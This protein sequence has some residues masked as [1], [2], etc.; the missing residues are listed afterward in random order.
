MLSQKL[1][2]LKE[3]YANARIWLMVA[4]GILSPIVSLGLLGISAVLRHMN[5]RL[6]W[7][8]IAN[9]VMSFFGIVT[10]LQATITFNVIATNFWAAWLL[11]PALIGLGLVLLPWVYTYK[12]T[13]KQLEQEAEIKRDEQRKKL[14]PEG[15]I[16]LSAKGHWL[17]VGTT[18]SGKT[19]NILRLVERAIQDNQFLA[20]VDGKGTIAQYSLYDVIIKLAKRCGRKVYVLNQ[21]DTKRSAKYNPFINCSAT[22]IKDMLLSM[23][24]WS[25]EYYKNLA[26]SYWLTLAK[27][28]IETKQTIT[29]NC[30][31][32]YSDPEL[33][34]VLADNAFAE[35]KIS[36]SLH[37]EVMNVVSGKEG[38]QAKVASTRFLTVYKGDGQDIFASADEGFSLLT[39]YKENAIC[40]FL[41]NPLAFDDFARSTGRLVVQDIKHFIS[42]RQSRSANGDNPLIVLDELGVYADDS[43]VDV[44]NKSRE[45][46]ATVCCAIQSTV[47]LDKISPQLTFQVINNSQNFLVFRINDPDGAEKMANVFGTRSASIY[48]D[49][50]R[51]GIETGDSS[52][53]DGEAYNVNPNLIK[54]LPVNHGYTLNKETGYMARIQTKF[55]SLD[56][57]LPHA[58]S[59]TRSKSIRDFIESLV[60]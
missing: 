12:I 32:E 40:L 24:V 45:S 27:F 6:M 25:E 19:A 20:V 33:L 15:E 21:T 26:A 31:A 55:V 52:R 10:L 35:D 14:I 17:A 51:F 46:N 44:L 29:F 38:E 56:D 37:S 28:L 48:T 57:T 2:I 36:Q 3:Q 16:N 58:E 53:R 8:N 1:E 60:D 39:A 49:R 59:T 30:L 34:R 13:I 54:Q 41:V 43:M 18:G 47:D 9:A 22:Q 5:T 7:C 42:D 50:M 23:G 4:G 11:S